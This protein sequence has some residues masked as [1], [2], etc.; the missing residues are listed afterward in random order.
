MVAPWDIPTETWSWSGQE[1]RASGWLPH[2]PRDLGRERRS[3]NRSKD[4]MAGEGPASPRRGRQ[5]ECG[6]IPSLS[7]KSVWEEQPP[8]R[9]APC[10][11]LSTSQKATGQPDPLSEALWPRATGGEGLP[12]GCPLPAQQTASHHEEGPDPGYFKHRPRSKGSCNVSGFRNTSTSWGGRAE[13]RPAAERPSIQALRQ[14]RSVGGTAQRRQAARLGRPVSA[15]GQRL[16]GVGAGQRPGRAWPA[17]PP[18]SRDSGKRAQPCPDPLQACQAVPLW[19]HL[20]L[21]HASGCSQGPSGVCEPFLPSS[22]ARCL[23]PQLP[24][25]SVYS[26]HP[27]KVPTG[28]ASSSVFGAGH[29]DA[30]CGAW[31][32]SP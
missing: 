21:G 16:I 15:E 31:E 20:T 23:H 19:L 29:L 13:G 32:I 7:W 2:P 27:L 10:G 14:P 26:P 5:A 30:D 25:P 22:P 1:V 24:A 18:T 3:P 4:A 17:E 12:V 11:P 28:H 9:P 6:S 8:P